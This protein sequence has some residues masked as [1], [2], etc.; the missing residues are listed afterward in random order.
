MSAPRVMVMMAPGTTRER[1]AALACEMAGGRAELVHIS[2]LA[3]GARDLRAY[4]MLVLPGGFAYGD[5]LS[6]GRLW[7]ADLVHRFR[8][9]LDAFAAAGK[10]VMGIGNGF[11]ALVKAGYLPGPAP[12]QRVTL[13]VNRREAFECRWVRLRAHPTS[14]C[15]FTAGL[16]EDILCPVA[17]GE[18][19]L[20]V[21]DAATRDALWQEG[22]VALTYVPMDGAV[23]DGPVG[24]PANPSGAVD[25]IAGICNAAGNVLGLM[26]H[27]EDHIDSLQHPRWTR[28]ASGGL[29]IR[30]FENGVRAARVFLG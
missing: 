6:A 8:Q 16:E 21:P 28:G 9:G 23:G 27:P 24:Y 29:G 11:Q 17:H 18:G 2:D 26:P 14:R 1:E 30:L 10:P 20:V 22:L 12:Q 5:D 13:A 4:Q 25:D 19:R 15:L 3:T 7:A